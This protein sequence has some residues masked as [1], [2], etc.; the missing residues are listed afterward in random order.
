MFRVTYN[1]YWTMFYFFLGLLIVQA[2]KKQ[3]IKIKK[4]KLLLVLQ[5]AWMS[6]KEQ[7]SNNSAV[8][9]LL[10]NNSLLLIQ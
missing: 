3:N 6:V 10:T 8:I 5:Y 2:Q 7:T 9:G 4:L 1:K